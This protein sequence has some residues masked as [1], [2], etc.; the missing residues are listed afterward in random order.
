MIF[1]GKPMNRYQEL[2]GNAPNCIPLMQVWAFM[3]AMDADV[4]INSTLTGVRLQVAAEIDAAVVLVG[5]PVSGL[6]TYI[7]RL[8][9]AECLVATAM[10]IEKKDRR[11]VGSWKSEMG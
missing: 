6:D 7:G 8:V 9:S 4:R 11:L 5:F 2:K 10:R 3:R 1:F